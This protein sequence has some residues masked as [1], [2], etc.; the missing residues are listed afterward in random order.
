[1]GTVLV[2]L[3]HY[4]KI[5]SADITPHIQKVAERHASILLANLEPVISEVDLDAKVYA[6]ET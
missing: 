5:G 2:P 1:M 6:A 3:L 4:T